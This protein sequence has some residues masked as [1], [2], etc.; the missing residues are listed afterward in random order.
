MAVAGRSATN[1]ACQAAPD[2]SE[3]DRGSS[4]LL[5]FMTALRTT[6]MAYI[7]WYMIR[8]IHFIP[9]VMNVT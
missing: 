8:V 2:D 1:S 4:A 3:R 6:L 7:S 5:L 9:E